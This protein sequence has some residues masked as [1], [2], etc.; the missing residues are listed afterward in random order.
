MTKL[1]KDRTCFSIAHRLSTIRNADM[2][3][4]MEKGDV[5][6]IGDHETLMKMNGKY[7]SLYNQAS[8]A[9]NLEAV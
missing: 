5:L 6:E 7:A 3:L 1:M 8:I 9:E 2:I 4:Y